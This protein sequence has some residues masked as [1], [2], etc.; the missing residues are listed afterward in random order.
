MERQLEK[1]KERVE[2]K[3]SRTNRVR[4]EIFDSE[5]DY[6][7]LQKEWNNTRPSRKSRDRHRNVRRIKNS[8]PSSPLTQ[9]ARS[10]QQIHCPHK[11][12]QRG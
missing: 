10:K 2:K 12:D 7:E 5:E 4:K 3:N 8:D 1:L 11:E 9:R 6:M